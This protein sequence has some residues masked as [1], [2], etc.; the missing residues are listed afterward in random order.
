[1]PGQP[2][3]ERNIYADFVINSSCFFCDFFR[4]SLF[5]RFKEFNIKHFAFLRISTALFPFSTS[6]S[7]F[8]LSCFR[9]RFQITLNGT[10]DIPVARNGTSV[11]VCV[12]FDFASTE[13]RRIHPCP[14]DY[15]WCTSHHFTLPYFALIGQRELLSLQNIVCCT[16]L[17]E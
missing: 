16:T 11:C 4:F 12:C 8:G 13:M 6:S 10:V 2:K 9:F 17:R 7:L 15:L 3:S 14:V 5:H 1:M